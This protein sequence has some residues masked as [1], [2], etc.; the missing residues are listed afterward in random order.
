[1]KPEAL[2]HLLQSLGLAQSHFD[3]TGSLTVELKF[4]LS[5]HDEMK[6]DLEE[7]LKIQTNVLL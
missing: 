6:E 5:G 4:K 2:K 7:W 1:M 3:L